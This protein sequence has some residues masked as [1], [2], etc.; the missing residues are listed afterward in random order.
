MPADTIGQADLKGINVD[1][2]LVGFADEEFTF[3]NDLVVVPTN[4]IE[5]R[6]W[7]KTSGNLTGTTTSSESVS[8]IRTTAFGTLPTVI[9][10]SAT[11]RTSYA[12]HFSAETPL[13]T[14]S[15]L[16]DM[17]PDMLGANL[18]DC[19]RAIQNQVD[20]VILNTLSG[21]VPLSGSTISGG[22]DTGD[23]KPFTDLLSGAMAIR[24]QGYDITNVKAW[25]HP[26]DY[27]NMMSVLVDYKGSS[28]PQLASSLTTGG[29]LTKVANVSIAVSN[30]ATS[31]QTLLFIPQKTAKWKTFTPL[32]SASV[33]NPGM[34][35]FYRVWEDGAALLT[36]PYSAC[37]ITH[38]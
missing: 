12:R 16:K 24:K 3:K 8:P 23:G 18:R 10:Q 20:Y 5:M 34:G 22:W 6:W 11:R 25:M 28:V 37:L 36:D 13:F 9:E 15:D 32:T 33:E 35:T 30:N 17:D 27:Q 38:Y 31:G 7:Q 1:K 4:A 14:Y 29:V 2:L 21:G 19:V 26:N